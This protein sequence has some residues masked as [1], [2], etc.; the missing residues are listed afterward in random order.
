MAAKRVYEFISDY[1]D[2]HTQI[3]V[4]EASYTNDSDARQTYRLH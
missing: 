2:T 1:K 4:K 3:H